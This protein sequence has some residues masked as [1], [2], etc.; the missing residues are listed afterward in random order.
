MA[1]G[2]PG[3]FDTALNIFSYR[4]NINYL[5]LVAIYSNERERHEKYIAS[6]KT[7]RIS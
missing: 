2:K 6:A 7:L 5:F 3:L 4:L 1:T